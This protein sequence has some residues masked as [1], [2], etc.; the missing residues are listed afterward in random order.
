M[1]DIW[2]QTSDAIFENDISIN[3]INDTL[4]GEK[5]RKR[6]ILQIYFNECFEIL[7]LFN[8]YINISDRVTFKRVYWI[9]MIY[10][11]FQIFII[12]QQYSF[13]SIIISFEMYSIFSINPE[14]KYY[15][16]SIELKK[17]LCKNII[18]SARS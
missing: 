6:K 9:A 18:L 10:Y 12:I 3:A 14:H 4:Y 17:I 16:F 8:L 7:L 2:I 15:K 13:I 11:R 5:K 1:V